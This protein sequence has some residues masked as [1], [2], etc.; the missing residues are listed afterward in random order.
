MPYYDN[1][2]LYKNAPMRGVYA[3][4]PRFTT[5]IK[6]SIM[7]ESENAF[8]FVCDATFTGLS[9]RF[10]Q[11]IIFILSDEERKRIVEVTL[12]EVSGR[13]PVV[14]GVSHFYVK[15][16]VDWQNTRLRQGQ[17][18]LSRRRLML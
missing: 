4:P 17:A 5:K 9:F 8:S 18:L 14:V 10:M 13:I 6:K 1:S 12:D 3:I 15:F 16:A 2:S 7:T 11:P